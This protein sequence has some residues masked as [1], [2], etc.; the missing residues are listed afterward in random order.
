MST[1]INVTVDSGGL[2]EQARQ[3]QAA[4]R[5]AQLEKERTRNTEAEA[6]EKREAR[7]EREGVGL[8]GQPRIGTPP[9]KEG[10]SDPLTARR[11]SGEIILTPRG[12]TV[13]PVQADPLFASYGYSQTT[14][15]A[16]REKFGYFY[17]LGDPPVANNKGPLPGMLSTTA[18]AITGGTTRKRLRSGGTDAFTA[19]AWVYMVATTTSEV[20]TRFRLQLQAQ[21]ANSEKVLCGI[22][23][24]SVLL[25]SSGVENGIDGQWAGINSAFDP[26]LAT[27]FSAPPNRDL[28][29]EWQPGAWN[30]VAVMMTAATNTQS[31]SLR[32]FVNGSLFANLESTSGGSN[33]YSWAFNARSNL[34]MVASVEDRSLQNRIWFRGLRFTQ[35]ARYA[36]SGF[37][38][39]YY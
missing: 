10:D 27:L 23:L 32:W 7:L 37:N 15:R 12:P 17:T 19:E 9:D 3:Q 20:S 8:D 36:A 18:S 35:R 30:H 11:K 38:P 5:Q 22:E 21:N 6:T 29:L 2:S 31:A 24:Y 28:S 13:G 39:T 4:A 34:L 1:Q 16:F 14:L 26:P 33:D 25:F